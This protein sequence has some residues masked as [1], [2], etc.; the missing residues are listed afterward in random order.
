LAWVDVAMKF[1][2]TAAAVF[3]GSAGLIIEN[4]GK[5]PQSGIFEPSELI[6]ISTKLQN[7]L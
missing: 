7:H 3:L 5:E 1:L 4:T 6:R 2:L